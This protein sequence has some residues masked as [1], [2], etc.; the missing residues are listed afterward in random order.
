MTGYHL[1]QLNVGT[2]RAPT[3]S[4]ELACAY[5]WVELGQAA[6]ELDFLHADDDTGT[7]PI[8]FAFP[9]YGQ[10]YTRLTVDSNGVLLLGAGA[11]DWVNRPLGSDGPSPR[12]A[13]FWDDLVVDSVRYQVL[14]TAP[15]RT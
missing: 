5:A 15:G 2:V 9:F 8:G 14:G 1:A 11:S 12:L 13:P 6:R 4:P 3:D 7:I 10:E